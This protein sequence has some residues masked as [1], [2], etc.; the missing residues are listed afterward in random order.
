MTDTEPRAVS[1]GVLKGG[2]G[3]TTTA[4]NTARELA[5]RNDSALVVDLDDNGHMTRQLG[6]EDAYTSDTNHAQRVLIDGEEP[7]QYA[8]NVVDGL[9]LFPAHTELESVENEL[10]NATMGSA[11]LRK[12][13]VDPLLGGEYEYVVVDCPANRGKLNDNAMYAT[14]NIIIPLKPESGYD[15]GLSNTIQR[16]VE[17][18][19]EYFELDILA[20]TPTALNGRIDQDTRDRGLLEQLNS[21]DIADDIVPSYA[22]ITDEE[23]DA[24]DAGEYEGELPGIRFRGA[25]DA[26]HDAALPVRDYDGS[27][28]QLKNYAELAR[29]VEQGGI[30][31]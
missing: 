6:F 23:W 9:D 28:D 3:K 29:I 10:R 11:R 15:S 22:R 5:H 20:V 4:I 1:V 26:A 13:L 19:R 14:R 2:F 12:H 7:T 8:V 21:L 30:D 24:I 18:A 25:I 17:D 16:L 27:C 31:R